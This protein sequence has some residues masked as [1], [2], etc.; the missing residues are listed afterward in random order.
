MVGV[1]AGA[2]VQIPLGLIIQGKVVP[3]NDAAVPLADR[4][5]VAR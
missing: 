4:H 2:K 5:A 1:R 3:K